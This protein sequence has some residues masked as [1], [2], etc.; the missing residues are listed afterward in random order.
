MPVY[1]VE[2]DEMGRIC[3]MNGTTEVNIRILGEKPEGRK[4]LE[5]PRRR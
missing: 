4:P 3:S 2:D 1:K 5:R